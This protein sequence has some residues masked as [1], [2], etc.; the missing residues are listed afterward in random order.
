MIQLALNTRVVALHDSS[1]FSLFFARRSNGFQLLSDDKG[2]L[3]SHAEL[4]KRLQ[5]MTETVFPAIAAKSRSTQ[6]KM[7]ERFNR[8]IL[9]NEF[10]DGSKVMALDPIH[11]DKLSPT[12]EG[13]Y[14]IVRRSTGGAYELKDGTGVLLN[15]KYAPSQLKLV[16]DDMDDS[17][18]YEVETISSHRPAKVG[19]GVDYFVKWKGFPVEANTWEHE[20]GSA[21]DA[22]KHEQPKTRI[23]IDLA[24]KG[25]NAPS[26]NLRRS[27]R[28]RN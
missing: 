25:T 18:I 5:Y 7:I 4:E 27:A 13:P 16:L 9:H 6:L 20:G 19:G 2:D 28:N 14:T 15:R 11:G 21:A 1:P 23:V 22:Q 12:Y 10:P 3:L 17:D 24:A 26:S 8:T